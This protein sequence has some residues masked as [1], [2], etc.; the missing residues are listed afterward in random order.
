VTFAA[1]DVN[2]DAICL[3]REMERRRDGVMD[4]RSEGEE[5]KECME[6]RGEVQNRRRSEEVRQRR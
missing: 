6:R 3:G 1:D 2:D 5:E 4:R